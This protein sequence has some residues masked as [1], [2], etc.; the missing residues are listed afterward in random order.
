MNTTTILGT[1]A[2]ILF[3]AFFLPSPA[4]AESVNVT[5]TVDASD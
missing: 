2:A 4:S 3:L 1:L 5:F